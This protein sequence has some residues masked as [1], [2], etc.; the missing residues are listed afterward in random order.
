MAYIR[1]KSFEEMDPEIQERAR[2]ILEKTGKLGEIFELLALDKDLYFA[3][4]AMVQNFLLKE[5]RLPYATKERIA[6]LVSQ[7]NQCTMCVDVHKNIAKMLGMSEEQVEETLRGIDAIETDERE[8]ALLRLTLRAADK[9]NYK[10]AQEE[11]DRVKA[12]GWSEEEIL[13]A[14]RI[15]AY[16]NYINTLSNI[17]GLGK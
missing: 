15:A 5:T 11:I 7:A 12:A 4:D 9:E 3:T 10:T 14:V 2:P 17:F 13:E 16:F 1:L 8:K 6:L